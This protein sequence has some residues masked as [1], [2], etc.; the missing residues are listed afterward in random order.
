MSFIRCTPW[1]GFI[2][3]YFRPRRAVTHFIVI[4]LQRPNVRRLLSLQRLHTRKVSRDVAHHLR[5]VT[6]L[7]ARNQLLPLSF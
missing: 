3:Y 1:N 5:A 6:F 2:N 4:K 7:T